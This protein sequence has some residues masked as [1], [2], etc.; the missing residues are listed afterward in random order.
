MISAI[1]STLPAPYIDADDGVCFFF[2][3][4]YNGY[5]TRALAHDFRAAGGN[6]TYLGLRRH[7]HTTL[8]LTLNANGN[9]ARQPTNESIDHSPSAAPLLALSCPVPRAPPQ[10][11]PRRPSFSFHHHQD[12]TRVPDDDGSPFPF[13]FSRRGWGAVFGFQTRARVC[14]K[15][16]GRH[17]AAARALASRVLKH[18][19]RW[20]RGHV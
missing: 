9:L 16:G 2:A 4:G 5:G 18:Q 11:V 6:G 10:S 8:T 20:W 3:L 13:H 17:T 19:T 12:E 15:R 14:A 1:H 7:P